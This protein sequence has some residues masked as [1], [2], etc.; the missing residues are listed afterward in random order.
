MAAVTTLFSNANPARATTL[1]AYVQVLRL[2]GPEIAA[3]VMATWIRQR[4]QLHSYLIGLHVTDGTMHPGEAPGLGVDID[5]VLAPT[6]PYDPAYL[7]TA[8]KTDGTV[9]S[10]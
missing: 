6:F 1:T 4:E 3:T 8:R 9:H 7:P 10:W 2:I 5:E